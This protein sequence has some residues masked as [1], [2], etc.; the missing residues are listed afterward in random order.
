MED[1]QFSTTNGTAEGTASLEARGGDLR[2]A[3]EAGLRALLVLTG[4]NQ[5]PPPTAV[6]SVPVQGEGEDPAL[7]FADLAESLLEEIEQFG[8][9]I[10]QVA[11]DGVLRRDDGG[12]R[13]WGYAGGTLDPAPL[14]ATPRLAGVPVVS[15]DGSHG[16]VLRA[17]LRRS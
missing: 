3:L 7:L 15:D 2:A 17:S 1:G 16:V 13:A 8:A 11:L 12:Y 4:V 5:A 10:A 6:R 9:G 14:G